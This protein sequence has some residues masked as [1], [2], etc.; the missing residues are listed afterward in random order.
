MVALAVHTRH[1]DLLG[2]LAPFALASLRKTGL[3]IDLDLK[4]L[5]LPG[6]RT[7]ADLVEDGPTLAELVPSRK[8]W[9]VLPHGGVSPAEAMEVVKALVESWPTVVVRSRTPLEGMPFVQVVPLLPGV[10]TRVSPRVWVRSGIGQ[11]KPGPGPVVDTPP[12]AAFN[13]ALAGHIPVGRW[14]RSWEKVWRWRWL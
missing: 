12:R 13:A 10:N 4:G 9:A 5:P 11:V 2:V 3:V 1:D 14:L 6:R 7:L 8:G